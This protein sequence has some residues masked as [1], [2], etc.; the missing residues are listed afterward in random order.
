MS[1]I[2]TI[3]TPR[4]TPSAFRYSMVG[5]NSS[6]SISIGGRTPTPLTRQQQLQ[7]QQQTQQPSTTDL[8][9]SGSTPSSPFVGSPLS[10]SWQQD[11]EN[12]SLFDGDQ[13]ED[14]NTNYSSS[15]PVSPAMSASSSR[16]FLQGQRPRQKGDF[17][18]VC[19]RMRYVVALSPFTLKYFFETCI[20]F[21]S[22]NSERQRPI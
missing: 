6:S 11:A 14:H 17:C 18:H 10:S 13:F 22:S 16:I 4:T 15:A 12:F 19:V 1:R 2:P 7:Q 9:N 5:S 8:N 21:I 3:N 20:T